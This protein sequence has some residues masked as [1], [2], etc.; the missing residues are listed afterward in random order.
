MPRVFVTSAIVVASM[1]ASGCMTANGTPLVAAPAETPRPSADAVATLA[2]DTDENLAWAASVVRVDFVANQTGLTVKLFGTAGG[3][4]AMNGL[5][6]YIAFLGDPHE[7]W[8]TFQ[9]GD[10]IDYRI[11]SSSSGRVALELHENT[12][13]SSGE[14]G[15]RNRR[16]IVSWIVGADGTPPATVVVTQTR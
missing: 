13:A 12:M 3:D 10:F 6:T 11:V 2:P 16:V 7:D 15:S 1:I 4:P 9:L 14:I 8:R 5:Y